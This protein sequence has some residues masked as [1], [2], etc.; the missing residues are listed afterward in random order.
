MLHL[1]LEPS[2]YS[3]LLLRYYKMNLLGFTEPEVITYGVVQRINRVGPEII[4][5][6]FS[7]MEEQ[8]RI[9]SGWERALI[10]EEDPEIIRFDKYGFEIEF[11]CYDNKMPYGWRIYQGEAIHWVV[12]AI[13]NYKWAVWGES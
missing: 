8:D 7:T 9:K 4:E 3:K 13:F 6:L 2:I 10:I 11:Y 12:E 5:A 1:L